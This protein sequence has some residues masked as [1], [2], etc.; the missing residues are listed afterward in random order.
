MAWLLKDLEF[1][2]PLSLI[3]QRIWT[4]LK[5][6][7]QNHCWGAHFPAP[8][9]ALSRKCSHLPVTPFN[10][11]IITTTFSIEIRNSRTNAFLISIGSHFD[12]HRNYIHL[13]NVVIYLMHFIETDFHNLNITFS[14]SIWISAVLNNYV[15]TLFIRIFPFLVISIAVIS[16]S[17]IAR[18]F[19]N[20]LKF[21]R[22]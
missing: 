21:R 6:H 18:T 7:S 16:C 22:D 14:I 20:V 15:L 12:V 13:S 19:I 11:T 8:S 4:N 2:I 5:L 10:D 1:Y 9:P 17:N 3:F